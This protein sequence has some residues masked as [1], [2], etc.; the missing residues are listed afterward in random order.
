MRVAM[1]ASRSDKRVQR[2]GAIIVFGCEKL[3]QLPSSFSSLPSLTRLDISK[4]PIANLPEG[5]GHLGDLR[6]LT[7]SCCNELTALP[8]SIT[9]LS[10]L[11][12]LKAC[13]CIKLASAPRALENHSCLRELDL[14]GCVLLQATLE[15]LPRSLETLSLGTDTSSIILPDMS[16]TSNLKK[17][18]LIRVTIT[19]ALATSRDLSQ[20]EHLE[21]RLG[22]EQAEFP[23]LLGFLSCLRNLHIS[24]AKALKHLPHD[25]GSA[26]PRLRQLHVEGAD[27][28]REIP[29]SV[30]LLVQLKSLHIE[31]PRLTHLPDTISSLTRLGDLSLRN[32]SSLTSLPS[33]FTNLTYLQRLDLSET[34]LHFLP[35]NF[36]HLARLRELDLSGCGQ[37]PSLPQH[38][39]NLMLLRV[40]NLK[41]CKILGREPVP[42]QEPML[43]D[44][45]A[46]LGLKVYQTKH[47]WSINI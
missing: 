12:T 31:A 35:P 47:I 11:K 21:L 16:T 5:I 7:L 19:D 2:H 25:L 33:S 20:I 40:L 29:N 30:S 39:S 8:A 34:A 43:E 9:Q 28:L 22:A 36:H 18:K 1:S 41:G 45:Y 38:L 27:V 32:C 14:T 44:L 23:L 4:C 37:L 46:R 15:S 17:L 26:L 24:N 10:R 13:T 42:G 6:E 3:Q